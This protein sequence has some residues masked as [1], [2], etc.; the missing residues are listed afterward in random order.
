MS[1]LTTLKPRIGNQPARVAVMQ[2]D[3]WRSDKQSSTQRGY[4]Y[5]WQKAREHHL[6]ANPLCVYCQRQG[7]VTAASVV[8][9]ITPHRGDMAMFWD[10]EN[11]QSLCT[12]CHSSVKQREEQAGRG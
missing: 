9:H 10:P 11:W 12:S 5:K 2:P 8:D 3:S 6:A 4:G 1:R 7:L